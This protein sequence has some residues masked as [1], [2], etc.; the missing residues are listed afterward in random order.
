MR[1]FVLGVAVVLC[2]ASSAT[3][4]Q[5]GERGGNDPADCWDWDDCGYLDA[6]FA[7]C[8]EG[9]VCSDLTPSGLLF[10]GDGIFRGGSE[11]LSPTAVGGVQRFVLA[12][13]GALP[14]AVETTGAIVAE[15]DPTSARSV[16]VTA[17]ESGG[18]YLRVVDP[19]GLLYDRIWLETANVSHATFEAF[20][21]GDLLFVDGPG[22]FWNGG[23]ATARLTA[24]AGERVVIDRTMTV[25]S[26]V[27]A[28]VEPLLG[29]DGTPRNWD[30]FVVTGLMNG[31]VSVAAVIGGVT[32]DVPIRVVSDTDEIVPALEIFAPPA[33]I[34]GN[35][36]FCFAAIDG[37]RV[38][39]GAPWSFD[40]DGALVS[41]TGSTE[42]EE[43]VFVEPLGAGRATIEVT[44][45]TATRVFE[46]M[47]EPSSPAP[48][49]M[50]RALEP[51]PPRAAGERALGR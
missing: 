2:A 38:V 14:F 13:I 31:D 47:V 5:R 23:R 37:G 12:D 48:A 49:P 40:V 32:R 7:P 9:E 26:G 39:V 21:V 33:T 16:L 43:C 36:T 10:V 15:V 30:A 19:D 25:S 51:V 1:S 46:S 34:H 3:P 18:G 27:A 35:A 6:G 11:D 22:A 45:G 17:V 29:D 42:V 28:E 44:G 4:D 8:P 50:P 24:W 41:A 20:H